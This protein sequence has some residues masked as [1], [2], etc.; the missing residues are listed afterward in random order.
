M[1]DPG[2]TLYFY[3]RKALGHIPHAKLLSSFM[4][5]GMRQDGISQWTNRVRDSKPSMGR[6][7]LPHGICSLHSQITGKLL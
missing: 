5:L 7:D 6:N 4:C 2:E 1:D 3:F